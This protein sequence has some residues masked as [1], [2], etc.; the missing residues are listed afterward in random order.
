MTYTELLN[1]LPTLTLVK[2]LINY[3]T[4]LALSYAAGVMTIAGAFFI[5][6][7]LNVPG[8]LLYKSKPTT[9]VSTQTTTDIS[10]SHPIYPDSS[11]T[12]DITSDYLEN[13][14]CTLPSGAEFKFYCHK[15]ETK[16]RKNEIPHFPNIKLIFDNNFNYNF[17]HNHRTY[18]NRIKMS[19]IG[20]NLKNYLFNA[21]ETG[22][23]VEDNSNH[24]CTFDHLKDNISFDTKEKQKFEVS[25]L[26]I[27]KFL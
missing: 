16:E 25:E 27:F 11:A 4:I 14:E 2:Q 17:V 7:N 26:F 21:R 3:S 8:N 19:S 6:S 18:F 23:D 5:A 9:S 20:V 15:N 24:N 22:A 13:I 1:L 10:S 12:Q